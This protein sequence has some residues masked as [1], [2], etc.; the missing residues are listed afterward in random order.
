MSKKSSIRDQ[1][2]D[3]IRSVVQQ[4][5][6]LF[7]TPLLVEF[8]DGDHN[9]AIFTNQV[10]YWTDRTKDPEGWF[11]KTQ[12]DW[13]EELHFSYYQVQRVIFGDERVQ[14]RKRN[15]SDVGLEVE[16]RM[17]PNGRNATFYRLDVPQFVG[18]FVEWIEEKFG[19]LATKVKS[20][21]NPKT[22]KARLDTTPQAEFA[23][24]DDP[25]PPLWFRQQE[26]DITP[27]EQVQIRWE[28]AYSSN[29]EQT[30]A[31]VWKIAHSQ[32]EI[33][34]DRSSF[35]IYLKH[36]TLVD[37]EPSSLTFTLA[38]KDTRN[39]D[40]VRYRLHRNIRR[41]LSDVF[42]QE[43]EITYITYNDWRERSP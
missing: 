38:V 21:L 28:N 18:M 26:P 32:L 7:T 8:F 37:Y 41:V 43:V 6:I 12:D 2:N 27:S 25:L 34:F 5:S 19:A 36:I 3:L 1:I 29:K 22:P 24:N 14:N 15:L 31:D 42:G 30:I 17:A 11:Y 4:N 23:G 39:I 9:A 33:Q 35:N 20:V 40:M 10:L 13:H 16:V